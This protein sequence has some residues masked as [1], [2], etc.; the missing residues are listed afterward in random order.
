MNVFE[1][2]ISSSILIIV[3][4]IIRALG[5]HEVPKRT[6]IILWSIVICRLLI[7]FSISSRLSFYTAVNMLKQAFR[8]NALTT[9]VVSDI[10]YTVDIQGV[11]QSI[12]MVDSTV[13]YSAFTVIWIVGMCVCILFF[14]V[15][16]TKCCREFKTSLPVSN[17]FVAWWLREH[18]LKRSIDIRVCDKIKAPLTFGILHPVILLPKT[19]DWTDET[20]LKYILTHEYVHIKRFDILIK[21]LL[22]GT[23]CVHW[24]NPCVWIMYIIANRDI[25]LSCD[26]A[27]VRTFGETTKSVYAM[28]LVGMKEKRS[29]LTGLSI[30]FSK[31][32]IE[33]R[34]VSIMKIK[35]ISRKGITLAIALIITVVTVF[36]TNA[37]EDDSVSYS[38]ILSSGDK[39]SEDGGKTWISEAEYD[40]L[41]PV[42]DVVWW[43][44]D[45]YKKMIEERKK[46]LPNMIGAKGGY[47]DKAGKYHK[48]V[49]DQKMV[50][51][52]IARDEQTLKE[53]KDG[54]KVSKTVDGRDDIGLCYKPN[55]G[56]VATSHVISYQIQDGKNVI[57]D[58]DS[59]DSKEELLEAVKSYCKDQVEAGNMTQQ[60]A[61]EFIEMADK[62]DNVGYNE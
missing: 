24:F 45:E 17:D 46:T 60:E 39:V 33:E 8:S 47:Y 38:T 31:N 19:T 11:E 30:N 59:Y 50:D 16:Y 57:F 54:L 27:V 56:S 12:G 9:T 20:R 5:L 15:L 58:L 3:V 14:M 53:I 34:I 62:S 61:D 51:E 21:L 52:A 44:Y 4:V 43:T 32:A 13:L 25:E 22:T 35:N 48:I 7:P 2:S 49:W 10:A 41:H 6:F 42:P 26:E 40:K 55:P 23:L 28:T 1:M 18:E 36:A 37:S 29:G